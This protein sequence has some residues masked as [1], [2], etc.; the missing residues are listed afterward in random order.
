MHKLKKEGMILQK[1]Q[2]LPHC[3]ICND[4]KLIYSEREDGYSVGTPC[5][6]LLL[7]QAIRKMNNSGLG[8]LL[9]TKRFDNYIADTPYQKVIK[10]TAIE[11]VEEFKKGNKYSFAILGQSGVGKTHITTAVAKKLLDENIGVNYYMADE[12]IQNLQ[13]C[14][15][16]EEN[17]NRE[18]NK[19]VKADVL[20]IDDLFKSSVTNYYQKENVKQEDLKEIFKVINYRYNKGLPILLNSEIHFER[21]IDIDQAVIGRINEMCNYKYL[22]SIKPDT[23]KNYRLQNRSL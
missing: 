19:I 9:E 22:T 2:V 20:F 10:E 17:Y 23:S 12:I 14:K 11:Y 4:Q 1:E 18:F 16:D 7:E 6:C 13:A 15:F 3:N 8:D 21:F 5:K